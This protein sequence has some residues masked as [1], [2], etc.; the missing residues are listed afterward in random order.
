MR[1]AGNI[2][3]QG[4]SDQL[5]ELRTDLETL[6]GRQQKRSVVPPT[7]EANGLEMLLAA[8]GSFDTNHMPRM[9]GANTPR[10]GVFGVGDAMGALD[11]PYLQDFLQQ[12]YREWNTDDFDANTGDVISGPLQFDWENANMFGSL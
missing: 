2:P 12:T 6:K 9:S 8:T 11:D 5:M 4:L 7:T 1:E 10:A 3:A